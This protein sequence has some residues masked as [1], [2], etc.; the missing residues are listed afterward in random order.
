LCYFC[1]NISH[2]IT[3]CFHYKKQQEIIKERREEHEL[4]RHVQQQT[5]ELAQ[6]FNTPNTQQ[7]SSLSNH[8][9]QQ[10]IITI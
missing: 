4:N 5:P 8:N 7:R 1:R 3:Y 9:P 6:Q 10:K 2:T